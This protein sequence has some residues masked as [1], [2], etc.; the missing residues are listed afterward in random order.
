MRRAGRQTNAPFCSVVRRNI[1]T[2]FQ[3]EG[4]SGAVTYVTQRADIDLHPRARPRSSRRRRRVPHGRPARQARRSSTSRISS[5]TRPGPRSPPTRRSSTPGA[6]R[7]APTSPWWTSNNATNT[8]TL[9][10]GA[11]TKSPLVVAVPGGPTGTIANANAADFADQPERRHGLVALPVLDRGRDD[12][13]LGADRRGDDGDPGRRQLGAGGRLQG[14]RRSLNDRLYATD[15]HN[16]RVDVFDASFKPVPLVNA[17]K[18]PKIPPGWAPFGIQALNGNIFVTYAMQDKAKHDDVAGGGL[19]YV[20]EFSPDGALLASVAS[21]GK[22]NAPLNAPWGL[23]MAPA[24]FG[25]YGGDLLVGNFGNGRISAYQQTS[26][27]AV[28][29]QGPAAGR[30]RRADRAR[31]PLGDRVRQR[32]GRRADARTCTSPPAR[33]ARS[34]ACSASSPSADLRGG[35]AAPRAPRARPA[36]RAMWPLGPVTVTDTGPWPSPTCRGKPRGRGA[37]ACRSSQP[38]HTSVA[39][40]D[41]GTWPSRTATFLSQRSHF[42]LKHGRSG[43]GRNTGV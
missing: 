32:L 43:Q 40:T 11:G 20:D 36:L 8:S 34:T 4:D 31:R 29:L 2:H 5:R 39:V 24:S 12:P 19:G 18:D 9:Y 30:K 16:G 27:D 13:R 41:T 21:K 42:R 37:T 22:P 17:F 35:C 28:G 33:P 6:S 10:N 7:P 3:R 25:V 1:R 23:A 15:F 38:C 26:A 14:P